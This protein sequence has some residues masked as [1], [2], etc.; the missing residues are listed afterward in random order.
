MSLARALRSG[1]DLL[2]FAS[3]IP[4]GVAAGLL[5]A[6]GAAMGAR[7]DWVSATL[8]ASGTL[9]VYNIDRLRDTAIDH[10]SAPARTR[11]VEAHRRVLWQV[12]GAAAVVAVACALAGSLAVVG[13]CAAVLAAGLLHRRLKRFAIAKPVY[14]GAAWLAVT[15]GIPALSAPDRA[16][17]PWVAAVYAATLGANLIAS[18][19]RDETPNPSLLAATRALAAIAILVALVGPAAVTPLA[20]VPAAELV[21]LAFF[22]PSEHYTLVALDGALLAGSLAALALA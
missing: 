20:A 18:D 9:V 13:L 8:A 12:T 1:I 15:A 2:A 11:F 22:R 4:A 7:P 10:R 17:V 5:L 3:A 19:L 21:A 14:V 16:V 6:A